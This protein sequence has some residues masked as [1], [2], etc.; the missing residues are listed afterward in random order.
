MANI[1]L[2]AS[3]SSGIALSV[4]ANT[5]IATYPSSGI[6][7]V[8]EAQ[9]SEID[10]SA[11]PVVTDVV[12]RASFE[13]LQHEIR[14][15]YK[16]LPL[17][18][19][20]PQTVGIS[21]SIGPFVVGFNPSDTLTITD[22]PAMTFTKTPFTD[23]V[24]VSQNIILA[25]FE[26][27]IIDTAGV[28]KDGGEIEKEGINNTIK[29][30]K[31]S[32]LILLVLDSSLPYPT[33][34]N[35]V[36]SKNIKKDNLLIIENKIDLK[37]GINSSEYPSNQGVIKMSTV[38]EVG[39]NELVSEISNYLNNGQN[40]ADELDFSVN[41]RHRD[42]IDNSLKFCKNAHDILVQN[43]DYLLVISE[44]KQ[45]ITSIGEIIGKTDNENMLDKLFS[46][47]CIG[48]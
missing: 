10:L 33:E 41:I 37:Y 47:F 15:L 35:E 29:L 14:A 18:V 21:D 24:S 28:H 26:I 31:D 11:D 22:T 8:A 44:I 34:L 19:F 39:L 17:T 38:E 25:D 27:E 30:L 45:A 40:E 46:N 1:R 20:P 36:I 4:S 32:D 12:Y 43:I 13:A 6:T 2:K 7:I 42:C 16:F 3:A 48:K 5:A 9:D 23:S